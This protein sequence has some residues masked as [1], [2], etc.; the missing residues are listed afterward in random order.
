MFVSRLGG[1]HFLMSFIECIGSLMEGSGLKE[2]MKSAFA[3]VEKMLLGKKY[4]SND[5]VL[6]MV[7]IELLR[8]AL[9]AIQSYSE[10]EN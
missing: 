7:L 4:P 5:R 1:M 8:N 6:R 9:P 3:G 10:L 2:I